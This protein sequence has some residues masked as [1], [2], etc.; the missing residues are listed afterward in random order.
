M[1]SLVV[2]LALSAVLTGT[3][4]AQDED[5]ATGSTAWLGISFVETTEG[6]VVRRVVTGSPAAAG[7]LLIGDVLVSVD[8]A[9]VESA[10]GL[11]EIIG[12]HAPGDTVALVV[13]RNGTERTLAIELGTT[14]AELRRA[15][16]GPFISANVD[17]LVMAEMVLRVELDAVDGGYQVLAGRMRMAS[18]LE[19]G[20]VITAVNGTPVGE[21]D[22]VA[23][24]T[25]LVESDEATLTLTVLRDGEELTIDSA[26]LGGFFQR[27]MMD[28]PGG[29][30]Q[31]MM[32]RFG[33]SRWGGLRGRGGFHGHMAPLAPGD[34][35]SGMGMTAPVES[36][37][38]A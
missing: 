37:T 17:P 29:F 28:C 6:L 8:G 5:T 22:W 38:P 19:V 30:C 27:G 31:G 25:G 1:I 18:D 3:I 16:A 33:G 14:P 9:A 34:E 13:L 35:A 26:L 20:D 21:V 23:L 12:A 4:L 15:Y 32:E 24:L 11:V 10:E 2:V 7:G 36:G